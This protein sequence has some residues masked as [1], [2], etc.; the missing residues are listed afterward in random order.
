MNDLIATWLSDLRIRHT[1]LVVGELHG[2]A[3]VRIEPEGSAAFHYCS[4]GSCI[5]EIARQPAIRLDAGDFLF[6]RDG[7]ARVVRGGDGKRTR[8]QALRSLIR[9]VARDDV[10]R[11]ATGHGRRSVVIGGGCCVDSPQASWFLAGLPAT[12]C[13]RRGGPEMARL[14]A[15][16]D[17][18]LAEAATPG[19][20]PVVAR[21]AEVAVLIAIRAFATNTSPNAPYLAGARDPHLGRALA[22]IE[23]DPHAPWTI[24]KLGRLAGM[25]RSGFAARFR[26]LVGEPP[27]GYVA[28]VR[29]ARAETL[30]LERPELALPN[31]A[32]QVGYASVAAFSVAFKR[33]RGVAPGE[34]RRAATTAPPRSERRAL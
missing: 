1:F 9:D 34:L 16:V 20:S 25:S 12:C 15:I 6:L 26:E 18:L 23:R 4:E 13:A 22:A 8:P 5:V 3:S 31:V 24:A 2:G 30:L 19:A 21:L 27:L 28:R 17:Q 33:I 29:M 7:P 10:V 11:F 14:A 32:Q